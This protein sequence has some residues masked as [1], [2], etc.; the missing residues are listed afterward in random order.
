MGYFSSNDYELCYN[1]GAVNNNISKIYDLIDKIE[2]YRL[3]M[4]DDVEDLERHAHDVEGSSVDENY[5]DFEYILNNDGLLM[6]EFEL[7]AFLN[8]LVTMI[9]STRLFINES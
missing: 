9:K 6:F 8:D 2:R 4:I 3:H 7:K 5:K 1:Q